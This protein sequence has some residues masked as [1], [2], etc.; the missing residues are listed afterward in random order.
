MLVTPELKSSGRRINMSSGQAR[1]GC[2][3]C[4]ERRKEAKKGGREG[5]REGG[6]EGGRD[7]GREEGRKGG[8]ERRRE[9]GRKEIK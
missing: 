9:G 3:V 1:L 4:S 8:V 6:K 7:G 2:S 5:R